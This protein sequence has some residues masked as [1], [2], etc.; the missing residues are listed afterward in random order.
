[1]VLMN[2]SD[3]EAIKHVSTAIDN[4]Y[5]Q[6]KG[7]ERVSSKLKHNW[8]DPEAN[9]EILRLINNSHTDKIINIDEVSKN[10]EQ[11]KNFV[12]RW[13]MRNTEHTRSVNYDPSKSL[14]YEESLYP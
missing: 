1:M 2:N 11:V 10:P 4:M 6:I 14:S 7:F 5:A 3:P 9:K 12:D 13:Y 8:N